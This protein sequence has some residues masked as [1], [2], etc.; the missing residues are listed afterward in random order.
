MSVAL[1][2]AKLGRPDREALGSSTAQGPRLAPRTEAARPTF[3]DT[4]DRHFDFVYLT[5]RRLGVDT[6]QLDDATQD[7]FVVVYRKLDEFAFR[8]GIKTWL[9]AI[10]LRIAPRYRRKNHHAAETDPEQVPTH[11]PSPQEQTIRNQAMQ[12][13]DRILAQMD[14]DRRILFIMAE[15]EQVPVSEAAE[16]LGIKLNTAYSRLRLARDDFNAQ[17]KRQLAQDQWRLP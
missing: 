13:M 11:Q 15:L 9:F 5:L 8:S 3:E 12:I 16:A 6:A 1:S 10:A 17:V 2:P 4:Y 14:E 7:V